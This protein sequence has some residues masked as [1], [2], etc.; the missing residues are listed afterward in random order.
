MFGLNVVG[1]RRGGFP[2]EERAEIKEAF[3]LLYASGRNVSQA[4]A[5]AGERGWGPAASEF[6]AFAAAATKRGLCAFR[7]GGAEF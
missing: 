3:K 5:A 2:P 6:F 7:T 4:L 1:L